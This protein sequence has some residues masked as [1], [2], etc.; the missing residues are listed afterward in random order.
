M[1]LYLK[2]KVENK[3]IYFHQVYIG[4]KRASENNFHVW[5]MWIIS[6]TRK[7]ILLIF[8]ETKPLRTLNIRKQ[9][10][11]YE[12]HFILQMDYDH[13]WSLYSWTKKTAWSIKMGQNRIFWMYHFNK[14]EAYIHRDIISTLKY[15]FYFIYDIIPWYRALIITV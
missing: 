2:L 1:L 3:H 12:G 11:T 10:C 6:A 5:K 14:Y 8:Q 9:N 15:H 4:F 7:D 13:L